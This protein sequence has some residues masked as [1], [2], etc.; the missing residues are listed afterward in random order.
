MYRYNTSIPIPIM[1]NRSDP[2]RPHTRTDHRSSSM[3]AGNGHG[4]LPE[5]SRT[6]SYR[7]TGTH[8][9]TNAGDNPGRC[10]TN[11]HGNYDTNTGAINRHAD[12]RRCRISTRSNPY[13]KTV[14]NRPYAYGNRDAVSTRYCQYVNTDTKPNG[15]TH[16][17]RFHSGPDP[18]SNANPRTN[19]HPNSG[20]ATRTDHT[21]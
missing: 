9:N 17:P 18:Y 20:T 11:A 10:P 7:S 6:N 2:T 1:A 21:G 15:S 5:Q 16:R 12:S 19:S 3:R 13:T 8:T 14:C 4:E